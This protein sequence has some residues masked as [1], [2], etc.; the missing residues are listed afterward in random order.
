MIP[1]GF[2][3][4]D[5]KF[6][7]EIIK[8]QTIWGEEGLCHSAVN[9]AFEQML[10]NRCS[11]WCLLDWVEIHPWDTDPCPVLVQL[12]PKAKKFLKRFEK[13]ESVKPITFGIVVPEYLVKEGI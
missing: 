3:A 5:V 10:T 4:I 11:V 7:D 13:G 1:Q 8:L 2:K 6:D 9:R 12:P